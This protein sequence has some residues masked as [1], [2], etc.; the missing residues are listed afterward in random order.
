MVAAVGVYEHRLLDRVVR[1]RVW[2]GLVT[3]ALLGIVTLQ[4]GLLELNGSIGRA[5]TRKAQLL[6]ENAALSIENSALASDEHVVSAAAQAGMVPVSLK[7]LRFLDAR[8]ASTSSAAAALRAPVQPPSGEAAQP[9]SGEAASASSSGGEASST[10]ESANPNATPSSP[11]SSSEAS[12]RSEASQPASP[13][14]SSSAGEAASAPSSSAGAS[15]SGASGAPV[16]ESGGSSA[17]G[18]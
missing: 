12:P 17:G 11:S 5:L 10:G 18:G 14:P 8:G 9:P 4:L 6:R 7:S 15:E 2:I 1:G 16:S 13:S 3:F